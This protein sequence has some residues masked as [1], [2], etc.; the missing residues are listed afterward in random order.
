MIGSPV[1]VERLASAAN[2][3]GAH[4]D[5]V[6][7]TLGRMPPDLVRAQ[8]EGTALLTR[9]QPM[10]LVAQGANWLATEEVATDLTFLLKQDM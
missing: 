9:L 6:I 5:W 3:G 2:A 7:A 8:L 10:L 4:A 1:A